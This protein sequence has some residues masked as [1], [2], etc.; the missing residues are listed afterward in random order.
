MMVY[1]PIYLCIMKLEQIWTNK[2]LIGVHFHF[3]TTLSQ[4]C[5]CKKGLQI[6]G[7]DLMVV[8][9]RNFA[10]VKQQPWRRIFFIKIFNFFSSREVHM[11]CFKNIF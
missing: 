11:R 7:L 1:I 6:K 5:N 8:Y 3:A 10:H 2:L 4:C 9:P